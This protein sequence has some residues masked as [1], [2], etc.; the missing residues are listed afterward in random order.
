MESHQG[1]TTDVVEELDD[2]DRMI[3]D[4]ST[5]PEFVESLRAAEDRTRL[6]TMLL[7]QRVGIGASQTEVAEKMGTT[8]SYIS[9]FENGAGDPLL[10]TYQRYARSV[11]LRLMLS[12]E[13]RPV[14]RSVP[15]FSL[16][17]S[18]KNPGN[19]YRPLAVV[20]DSWTIE[21][22]ERIGAAC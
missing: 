1:T 5:D 20:T 12:L 8:Q 17:A 4:Y 22:S 15:V 6:R 19:R 11:G 16:N 3:N 13:A 7:A 2:L 18:F 21:T 14:A 9:D 10:S